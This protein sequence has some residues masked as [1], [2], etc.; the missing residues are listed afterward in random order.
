MESCGSE[1][2]IPGFIRG[3][4]GSIFPGAY[5]CLTLE[6]DKLSEK[7]FPGFQADSIKREP[8]PDMF[9]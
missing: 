2:L 8:V 7:Y 6:I 9:G 3:G 5:D 1:Y 4:P